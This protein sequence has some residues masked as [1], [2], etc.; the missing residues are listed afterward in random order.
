MTG[1]SEYTLVSKISLPQAAVH[2]AQ[3][4]TGAI[5]L[6]FEIPMLS[7]SGLQIKF[8]KVLQEGDSPAPKKWV[9]Y[10]TKSSSYV[11]RI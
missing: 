5:N 1:G 3:K 10:L 11:C 2:Q 4:E 8:L 9:R 6:S 7:L